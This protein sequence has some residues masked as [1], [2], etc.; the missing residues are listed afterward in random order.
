VGFPTGD[1]RRLG[2][3]VG[4][5]GPDG[6]ISLGPASTTGCQRRVADQ[7]AKMLSRGV[8]VAR[9]G[10]EIGEDLHELVMRQF[11]GGV[12]PTPDRLRWTLPC[13]SRPPVSPSSIHRSSMV[14]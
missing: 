8:C 7:A 4:T 10:R 5:S 1:L 11:A 14:E 2:M 12:R 9:G 13:Q 3:L 6:G